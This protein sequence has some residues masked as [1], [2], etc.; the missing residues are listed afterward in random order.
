ML[1]AEPTLRQEY[2]AFV[3]EISLLYTKA[4]MQC[5]SKRNGQITVREVILLNVQVWRQSRTRVF[6]SA[7]TS[8]RLLVACKEIRAFNRPARVR[9]AGNGAFANI[10]TRHFN[11]SA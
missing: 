9:I 7:R 2:L 10:A 1:C 3:S 4:L 11:A 6:N 5:E 8:A